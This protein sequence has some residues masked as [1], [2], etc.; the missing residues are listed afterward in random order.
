VIDAERSE[1]E[2]AEDVW[3]AVASRLF[4]KAA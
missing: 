1:G 3:R 2:I 4:D